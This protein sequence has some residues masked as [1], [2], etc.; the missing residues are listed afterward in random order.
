[1]KHI[2]ENLNNYYHTLI[3]NYYHGNTKNKLGKGIILSCNIHTVEEETLGRDPKGG[4]KEELEE[5]EWVSLNTLS[6]K[7]TKIWQD[8]LTSLELKRGEESEFFVS[9]GMKEMV[10]LYNSD[11]EN[12]NG[13]SFNEGWQRIINLDFILALGKI[14]CIK[15]K[16]WWEWGVSQVRFS[17]SC[18][19]NL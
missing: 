18:C 11:E 17:R 12:I 6:L 7:K 2:Q 8:Y 10:V 13:R 3:L 5:E 19:N 4:G 1:M 16:D 9:F 14:R 15:W